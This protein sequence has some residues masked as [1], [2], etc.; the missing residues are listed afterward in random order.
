MER[1]CK[2]ACLIGA[3]AILLGSAPALGD[4]GGS[5]WAASID[6]AKRATVGILRSGEIAPSEATKAHFSIRGTGVH[7]REGYVVTARHAVKREEG[8]KTVIPEEIT[9]LTSDL[10]ELPAV[11]KGVSAFL[12]IAVYQVVGDGASSLSSAASLGTREPEPGDE[13]FTVGY[14]LGWGPTVAFG[15][16]GN[17]NTFLPTVQSRLVQVD[18][19]ACS[20][21][22]GGGLFNT[23]G[24]I[25]GVVHA[26][27]QTETLRDER[28][29]S[30]FAF[31][32]PG[33]LVQRITHALIEGTKL[34]F[35]RLGVQLTAVKMG[36]Q[37][38]VAVSGVTGP[39]RKGGIRKGDI[40]LSIDGTP[41][42]DAAQLKTYLVEHTEPGQRV[43][44]RVLRDQA[45][46]VF[47]ISLGKT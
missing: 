12:D 35:S 1:S 33:R 41:I 10:T 20:G 3:A 29:C 45:T 27:I 31:A 17:A 37:W 6:H 18:M 24:E 46:Q 42:R 22:S 30:R 15:R 26:I 7:L 28:R 39:A 25:V 14:P 36:R 43:T 11:L 34:S 2:H 38:R 9:V 4:S 16:I 19:S 23:A 21:N 8:G 40:L 13:A 32:V 47:H 44:L 5:R